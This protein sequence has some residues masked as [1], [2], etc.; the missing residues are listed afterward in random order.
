MSL[1]ETRVHGLEQMSSIASVIRDFQFFVCEKWEI[2]SDRSGSGNTAN[3]GSVDYI[4]DLIKRRG[5][6]LNLGEDVFDEYWMNYGRMMVKDGK[7]GAK[8]LTNL[9]EFLEVK[10]M[11]VRLINPRKKRRRRKIG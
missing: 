6:F 10:G 3:I 8:K 7:G 5:V 2:A 11:D 1:G 4:E 9:R